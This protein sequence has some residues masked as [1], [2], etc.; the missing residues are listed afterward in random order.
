MLS[1]AGTVH[2]TV[3]LETVNIV[4]HCYITEWKTEEDVVRIRSI[5]KDV[6]GHEFE[7]K[8]FYANRETALKSYPVACRGRE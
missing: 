4:F 6:L 3:H 8:K 2:S 7:R 5:Q 1:K